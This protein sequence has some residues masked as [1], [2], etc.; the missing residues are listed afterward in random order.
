M[1][2]TETRAPE[3]SS[4]PVEV[5]GALVELDVTGMT[6]GSCAARVQRVLARQDGVNGAIVNY[7]TGRASVE[8]ADHELD[9]EQ[10][11]EAVRKAGYDAAP[12]AHSASEQAQVFDEL[13][14][15]EAQEQRSLLRRI[16]VAVPLAT[17]ITVLTYAVPHDNTARWL[18]AV[19]AVPVLFWCGLPFL[20]SAWSRARVRA[21]N[22]DTLIALST[23]AAFGYSTYMLLSA[24]P[25]YLQIGR[26]HV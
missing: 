23:L 14:R 1:S 10:L 22:M 3:D 21:T 7:A 20:R 18:C 15:A 4:P 8:L 11:I 5:G 6:C 16:A 26:A 9:T 25:V 24:S 12:V 19:M 17:A 2:T 13:D